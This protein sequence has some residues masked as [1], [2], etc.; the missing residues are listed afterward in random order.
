[1]EGIIEVMPVATWTEDGLAQW[2]ALLGNALRYHYG[3]P[4][5]RDDS[6][7]IPAPDASA[8]HD[9]AACFDCKQATGG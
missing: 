5:K 6:D 3:L 1:M 4:P 7:P 2:L 9:P 8:P